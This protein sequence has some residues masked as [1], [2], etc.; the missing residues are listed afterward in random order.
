MLS[1]AELPLSDHILRRAGWNGLG[2][3]QMVREG[4]RE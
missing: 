4:T 1:L 3:A 2:V